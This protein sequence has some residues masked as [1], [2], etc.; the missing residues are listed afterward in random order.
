[1]RLYK[2]RS[3]SE[4]TLKIF[5]DKKIWLSNAVGLN[6]PFECSMKKI[7]TDWIE[8]RYE[9]ERMAHLMGFMIS[10]KRSMDSNENFW[11]LLPTQT[12]KLLRLL[13]KQSIDTQYSFFREFIKDHTG[14]YPTDTRSTF[15]QFDSQLSAVGIFS[16]SESSENQLLWAHYADEFRGIAIGFEIDPGSKLADSN[17]CVKVNYS[18]ELPAFESDGYISQVIGR[19]EKIRENDHDPSFRSTI[20]FDGVIVGDEV[21]GSFDENGKN[22]QSTG[23]FNWRFVDADNLEGKFDSGAASSRGTSIVSRRK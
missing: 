7:A 23:S 1:M 2:Y 10:A 13:K 22:R 15:D 17:H 4:F 21:R 5:E 8:R 9:S 11:S 19:G 20:K 16:L 18:E 3:I 14:Y 12:K 6:D